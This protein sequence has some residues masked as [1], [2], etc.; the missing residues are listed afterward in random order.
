M[1]LILIFLTTLVATF[2]SALSGGG[3]S[4][5]NLPV[6]IALGMP[7]P[8]A[9]AVQKV[10]STFW[11]LPAAYNY[12]QGKSV[13]WKFL[14]LFSLLG[15][16][17]AYL[18]VLFVL[19][20]PERMLQVLVGILILLLVAYTFFAKNVGNETGKTYSVFRKIL[21]YP[22]ALVMGFYESMF[23]A[24]NGILF[25]IIGYFTRGFDFISSLGY[26]FAAAFLWCVF[27][28]A[29]LISEGYIDIPI[30][31]A[32]ALGSILGA[33]IGSKFGRLK[34]NAYIR[35][36]FLVVGFTLGIKLVLGV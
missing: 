23:G 2:L 32:A 21:A 22:A 19:S 30:M 14:V 20:V 35:M 34:G 15:L 6:F 17:G 5:I 12:L 13:D 7:F 25:V 31:T 10:S 9:T 33:W 4:I 36:A 8:L 3:A 29:L 24:G 28:S 27:A 11:V 18:G 26:Y 16:F 1:E